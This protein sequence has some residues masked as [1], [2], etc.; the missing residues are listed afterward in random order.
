MIYDVIVVGLGAMGSATAHHLARRGL[1][2]L[3]LNAFSPPHAFGSSH[4]ETRI[5]REAYFEH[6]MYVPMVQ[7]AYSLWRDLEQESGTTLL[8]ETG[9]LMIG[10]R[11]SDLVQGARRSAE[12]HG[13]RYEMLAADEVHKRFP[14]LRPQSDMVAVWEPHAGV[15]FADACII[16][17][18]TAARRNG[19]ELH[20]EESVQ[21]WSSDPDGLR[22]HTSQGEYLARQLVITAGAWISVLFPDLPLR[23]ERQVLFWFDQGSVPEMFSPGRCP[24]H[25]WQFDGRRFFYGFPDLGNGVKVAFHHGGV[26]TDVNRMRRSVSDD[27]VQDI[28]VVARRFLAGADT[29]L[30]ATAVCMYTNTADEHF[31]IDR[32]P[33][34]ASVLIASAC[35]GHGFKF[36]PVIGEILADLI[37][38]KPPQLDIRLFNAR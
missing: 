11:N 7:R 38:G 15:L 35:S 31:W 23:I 36:S 21:R 4:G 14:A 29:K 30:R 34:N 33:R 24:V 18:L 17:H 22:V 19:A 6:P 5:I 12:M 28:R 2:V 13:L 26:I 27:E 8:M 10:E 1:R 3:G 25:L 9:G 32:D 20:Y 16:A 37:E